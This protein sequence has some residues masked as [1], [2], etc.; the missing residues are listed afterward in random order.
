MTAKLIFRDVLSAL[1]LIVAIISSIQGQST[2]PVGQ[3]QNGAPV[4]TTTE[5]QFNT[6]MSAHFPGHTYSNLQLLSATDS[7]GLFYYLS[8]NVQTSLETYQAKIILEHNGAN[9]EFTSAGCEMSCA[10]TGNCTGCDQNIIV[11][12]KSQKCTCNAQTGEGFGGCTSK[13]VFSTND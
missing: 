8:A 12:C 2:V 9:I 5:S 11:R 4:L 13:I 6:N 3:I 1:L 10:W 7:L